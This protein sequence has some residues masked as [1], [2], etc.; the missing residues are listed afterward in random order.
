M[1]LIDLLVLFSQCSFSPTMKSA[2]T[3]A[4]NSEAP[5]P[6]SAQPSSTEDLFSFPQL[7]D[8]TEL[9]PEEAEAYEAAKAETANITPVGSMPTHDG[10]SGLVGIS[11]PR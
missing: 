6:I 3:A 9:K 10:A 1:T 5:H 2:L 8:D 4:F 11:N 7:R